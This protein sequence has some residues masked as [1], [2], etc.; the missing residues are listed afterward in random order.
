MKKCTKCHLIKDVS[1]YYTV[2]AGRG[3]LYG[4]CKE[5]H[6]KQNAEYHRKNRKAIA[7][8]KRKYQQE[9]PEIFIAANLRRRA[10]EGESSLSAE[11]VAGLF[12]KYPLCYCGSVASD[13]EHS[14]PVS[15]GGGNNLENLTTLCRS[16]N[17]QKRDKTPS[18]YIDYLVGINDPLKAVK[19]IQLRMVSKVHTTASL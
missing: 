2:K 7:K 1:E 3:G 6:R 11:D 14:L 19:Y 17:V 8:R 9:R 16:C 12:E 18:E 4:H 10:R 5:C 13:V 15:R